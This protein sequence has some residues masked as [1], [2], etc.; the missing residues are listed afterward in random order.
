MKNRIVRAAAA[1][2]SGLFLVVVALRASEWVSHSESSEYGPA[3]D[4]ITTAG[5]IG[6]PGWALIIFGVVGLIVELASLALRW[7]RQSMPVQPPAHHAATPTSV[8]V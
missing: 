2:L 4:N 3:E 5:L 7:L 6:F 1:M 8:T